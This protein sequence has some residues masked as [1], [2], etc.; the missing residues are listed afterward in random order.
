MSDPPAG[1]LRGHHADREPPGL[2]PSVSWALDP[3]L[4][5]PSL[6]EAL[7]SEAEQD[8]SLSV[9]LQRVLAV[10]SADPQRRLDMAIAAR[11]LARID[12]AERIADIIL[13][14]AA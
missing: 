13:E 14:E 1:K 8:D 10:L 2:N 6:A 9:H 4:A 3:S 11:G 12:A 5:Q 7:Q